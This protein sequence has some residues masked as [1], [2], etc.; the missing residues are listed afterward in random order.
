MGGNGV[1]GEFWQSGK[2][3]NFRHAWGHPMVDHFCMFCNMCDL[4]QSY[5]YIKNESTTFAPVGACIL[6][7]LC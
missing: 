1:E 2:Y 6:L 7:G 3:C 4:Y 5:A